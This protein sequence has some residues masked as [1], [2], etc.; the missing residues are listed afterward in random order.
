MILDTDD[1]FIEKYINI[2]NFIL[3]L[4]SSNKSYKLIEY[5]LYNFN[6]LFNEKISNL[7]DTSPSD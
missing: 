4:T 5:A 3:T 2:K 1:I 7:L 6:K